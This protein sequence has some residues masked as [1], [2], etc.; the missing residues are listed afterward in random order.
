MKPDLAFQELRRLVEILEVE[1]VALPVLLVAGV[2]VAGELDVPV[3][4][5]LSSGGGEP[6]KPFREPLIESRV[7]SAP[8]WHTCAA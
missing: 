7:P 5:P 1:G 3:V 4:N 8:G 2:L 6:L